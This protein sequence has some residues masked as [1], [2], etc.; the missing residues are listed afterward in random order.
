MLF[1]SIG[2]SITLLRPPNYSGECFDDLKRE[3]QQGSVWHGDLPGR[4]K[5]GSLYW[6]ATTVVP[7]LDRE[8]IP[9]R[10]LS[11]QTDITHQKMNEKKLSRS[12]RALTALAEMQSLSG[13]HHDEHLWAQAITDGLSCRH[14][15][16]AAWIDIYDLTIDGVI[17][18]VTLTANGKPVTIDTLPTLSEQGLLNGEMVVYQHLEQIGRAHV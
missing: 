8:K 13:S 11:I 4:R 9:E 18:A 14:C 1:R 12:N 17:N 6:V 10:F 2:Q 15:Y 5:D 3:A 16:D 7:F